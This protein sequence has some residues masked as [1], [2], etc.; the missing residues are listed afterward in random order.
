MGDPTAA[1]AFSPLPSLV[2]R[3]LDSYRE[4]VRG[5]CPLSPATV[6]HVMREDSV[7]AASSA[8]FSRSRWARSVA[9]GPPSVKRTRG[10]RD[11]QGGHPC[12][13][14]ERGGSGWAVGQRRRRTW[15]WRWAARKEWHGGP[16][17]GTVG[18]GSLLSFS[19]LFSIPFSL[20]PSLN[21]NFE[22]EF[23]PVIN[24]FLIIL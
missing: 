22:F 10:K 16:K 17:S 23:E 3:R 20:F 4:K 15:E 5:R 18:P 13:W 12:Q 8:P 24:L 14:R 21:L 7:A 11:C 2:A 9:P 19:I 1:P 6:E